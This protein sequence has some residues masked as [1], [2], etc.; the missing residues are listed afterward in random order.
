MSDLGQLLHIVRDDD[1]GDPQ[2]LVQLLDE[3]QDHAPRD[4]VQT[5]EGFIVNQ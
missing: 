2:G 5:H 1:A 3:P 4:R